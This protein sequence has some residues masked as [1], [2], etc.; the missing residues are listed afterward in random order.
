MSANETPL[1][2]YISDTNTLLKVYC[3]FGNS[4]LN[5]GRINNLF[6]ESLRNITRKIRKI[7]WTCSLVVKI[8]RNTF[9]LFCSIFF[10]AV[11]QHWVNK[12]NTYWTKKK[13]KKYSLCTH[14]RL[15]WK[16]VR[17]KC[18]YLDSPRNFAPSRGQSTIQCNNNDNRKNN[19][20]YYYR[21][22]SC[23][24]SPSSAVTAVVYWPLK[25]FRYVT[26]I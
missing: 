23:G 17:F 15:K 25:K 7:D 24:K 14:E 9:F 11:Q 5:L 18:H 1:N 10:T 8:T 22:C 12:F 19:N 13:L 2:V 6:T 21:F 4:Y 20:Y 3:C 26:I 16:F